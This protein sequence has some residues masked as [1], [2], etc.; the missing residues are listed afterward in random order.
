MA[1]NHKDI[2]NHHVPYQ[3][4]SSP[5]AIERIA[6]GK[7]FSAKPPLG[8]SRIGNFLFQEF[9]FLSHQIFFPRMKDSLEKFLSLKLDGLS[10]TGKYAP[11]E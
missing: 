5:L 1:K 6:V 8:Q 7:K 3:L 4:G 11:K 2:N 10:F 9:D